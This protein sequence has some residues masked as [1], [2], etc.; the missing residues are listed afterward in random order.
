MSDD[1]SNIGKI[2]SREDVEMLRHLYKDKWYS[3]KM[4]ADLFW[5]TEK[6]IA[7]RLQY[8]GLIDDA[9]EFLKQQSKPEIKESSATENFEHT[10]EM[11]TFKAL[12]IKRLKLAKNRPAYMICED[13]T[14]HF[15]A[16]NRPLTKREMMNI[17]W[18]KDVK[19][20]LYWEEFIKTIKAVLTYY[21]EHWF[22]I[23][24]KR[25]KDDWS[26][27][28]KRWF[29]IEWINRETWDKWDNQWYDI[30]WIHKDTWTRF[31]SNWY[32]IDWNKDVDPYE[33]YLKKKAHD[34][35]VRRMLW[36]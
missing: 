22:N 15:M 24:T 19:L 4:L 20:D 3:I 11:E 21:D 9:E 17:P 14:L 36:I 1:N 35:E 8:L 31:N 7:Y 29:S 30:D 6:W 28:D 18:I 12:K 25:H 2:R 26:F 32:D 13:Y 5:R 34:D 23:K 16:E 33:E 27:Y 10:L